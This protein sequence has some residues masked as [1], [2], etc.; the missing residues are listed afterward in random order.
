MTLAAFPQRTRACGIS[1]ALTQAAEMTV[2][3]Q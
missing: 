3:I 2:A 1:E